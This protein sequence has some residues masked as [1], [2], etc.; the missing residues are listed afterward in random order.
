MM[1]NCEFKNVGQKKSNKYNEVILN[2]IQDLPHKFFYK[3]QFNNKDQQLMRKIPNQVWN[4]SYNI[5]ARGFTLIELL[6]VVLIIGILAAVALPQYQ[7]A[8]EKAKI[9]EAQQIA[10][11]LRPAIDAYVL[12]NGTNG[13]EFVGNG[14]N[15]LDIDVESVLDCSRGDHDVCFGK[16][17]GYD[18]F[19]LAHHTPNSC[20]IRAWRLED[21]TAYIASGHDTYRYRIEWQRNDSTGKWA[22]ICYLG[23]KATDTDKQ[24]CADLNN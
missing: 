8:V 7:K 20:L 11:T 4:D 24:I 1:K 18:A 16:H 15:Q 19:C 14:L 3:K 23:T 2:S 21:P 22:R 13:G 12:A 6:V 17:F 5:T 9:A 10:A